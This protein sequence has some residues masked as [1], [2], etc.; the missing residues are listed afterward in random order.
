MY[1]LIDFTE[2]YLIIYNNLATYVYKT[3]KEGKEYYDLYTITRESCGLFIK[4]P[5]MSFYC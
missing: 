3:P 5:L 1:T 2:F 4:I